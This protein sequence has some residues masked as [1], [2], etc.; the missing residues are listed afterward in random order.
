MRDVD[1]QDLAFDL[2]TIAAIALAI[3]LGGM[4]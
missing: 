1:R 2:L 3:L 4:R